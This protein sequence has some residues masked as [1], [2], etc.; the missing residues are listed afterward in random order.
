MPGWLSRE[1]SSLGSGHDLAVCEL[2][3]LLQVSSSPAL[4]ST[5]SLSL[6]LSLSLSAPRGILSLPVSAPH[7]SVLSLS[8]K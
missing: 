4:S 5:V 2:E 3:A 6:S 7:S 8:Q 1:A